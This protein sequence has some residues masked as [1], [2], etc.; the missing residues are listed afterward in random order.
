[1][2]CI[3]CGQELPATAKFCSNCG[4]RVISA[5]T[6][7]QP[8]PI[9]DDIASKAVD[10]VVMDETP[11]FNDGGY[12]DDD[13]RRK[14]VFFGKGGAIESTPTVTISPT[15]TKKQNPIS[16]ELKKTGKYSYVCEF[17]NGLAR[18]C[19]N[20]KEGYINDRGDEVI[21]LQYDCVWP[22]YNGLSRVKVNDKWGLIN[23]EGEEIV[24]IKYDEIKIGA[25]GIVKVKSN[26]LYGLIRSDG[27]ELLPAEYDEIQSFN[28]NNIS[29]I[30]KGQK[31]GYIR[32]EEGQL[33]IEIPC[34]LDSAG[35]FDSKIDGVHNAASVCYKGNNF[36]IDRD[37]QVYKKSS[38][39]NFI[40][41]IIYVIILAVFFG[42]VLFW[43]AM[44][45]CKYAMLIGDF[46]G[47]LF[48]AFGSLVNG[49]GAFDW[50]V[51]AFIVTGFY[52]LS[53]FLL[54]DNGLWS[55]MFDS[56]SYYRSKIN[57]KNW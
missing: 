17:Y 20:G 35:K 8:Q 11:S 45:K 3:E 29:I 7:T 46:I 47:D 16:N 52:Y 50:M 33:R 39:W 30:R 42:G 23:K 44:S 53:K 38:L 22:F 12:T 36:Y 26:N 54:S 51:F 41:F 28:I 34:C 21:P 4:T 27:K 57:V 25:N 24:P 55:S 19:L 49:F 6:P 9:L 32:Y 1:M 56:P 48:E 15:A 43:V 40:I 10:I 14:A 37:F 2:F 18:V 13:V 31:F 5:K